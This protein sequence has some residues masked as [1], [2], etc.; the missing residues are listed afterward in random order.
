VNIRIYHAVL[1]CASCHDWG[2][3]SHSRLSAGL[4]PAY[5]STFNVFAASV[6]EVNENRGALGT[7][8]SVEY[9]KGRK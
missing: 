2:E 8:M 7:Q 5:K 4:F 3:S 1:I 9:G 6:V